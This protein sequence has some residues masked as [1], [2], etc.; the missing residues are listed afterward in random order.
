MSASSGS[1]VSTKSLAENTLTLPGLTSKFASVGRVEGLTNALSVV[2]SGTD[3]VE[4][5]SVVA[6]TAALCSV[7]PGKVISLVVSGVFVVV[8]RERGFGNGDLLVVVVVIDVVVSLSVVVVVGLEVVVSGALVV[9]EKVVV[10]GAV[11]VVTVVFVVTTG[12]RVVAGVVGGGVL[13]GIFVV[14][15]VL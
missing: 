11:L 14:V 7:V 10:L 15:S 2:V 8:D 5:N 3:V 9:V 6:T 4:T 13:L 1:N 12:F